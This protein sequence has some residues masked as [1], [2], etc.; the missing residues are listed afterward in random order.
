MTRPENV[1]FILFTD[2]SGYLDHL[3]G[4][5][6]IA[7][8]VSS[9]SSSGYI[10]SCGCATH[11]ETGRAEF[12]AVLNGL[13]SILDVNGWD[14]ESLLESRFLGNRMKVHIVSDRADLVGSINRVYRRGS[15][16][17]LWAQ[18]EWY[19]RYMEITAEHVKRETNPTQSLVD[20][21]AS[22]MRL[23]LKDFVESEQEHK[24]M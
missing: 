19:E 12:T 22:L 1:D 13:H 21:T 9:I 5:G 23:V 14:N 16:S 7:V 10:P 3:G 20:K 8:G 18:Y 2:G 17:D 15:N 11:T 24:H 4:F 6:A